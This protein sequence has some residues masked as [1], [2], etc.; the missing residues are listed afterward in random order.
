MSVTRIYPQPSLPLRG[1]ESTSTG[2]SLGANAPGGISSFGESLLGALGEAS[3][4]ESAAHTATAR[5]VEGSGEIHEAVIA[6]E[7][8]A[9]SLRFAVQLKNRAIEA[10]REIMN[11]QV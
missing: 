6:H 9:V 1:P 5:M 4:A 7:K 10:Y 8:A 11:T 2:P 3:R